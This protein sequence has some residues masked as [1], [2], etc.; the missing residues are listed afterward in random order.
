MQNKIVFPYEGTNRTDANRDRAHVGAATELRGSA[1]A[2]EASLRIAVLCH[3]CYSF[4]L[5]F[6]GCCKA[7]GVRQ[8]AIL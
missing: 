2:K 3:P 7:L 5:F 4:V 1:G 8:Y 6:C